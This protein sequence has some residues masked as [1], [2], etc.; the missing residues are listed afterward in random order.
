MEAPEILL[1]DRLNEKGV[2]IDAVIAHHPEAN[3]YTNF[4]EVM[5]MQADIFN[6]LGVSIS[7]AQ[8]MLSKRKREVAEKLMPANHYR[9]YDAARLLNISMLNFHTP[10]DNCV[11]TY[12]Q[13][14]FDKEK[15]TVIEGLMDLLMEIPEYIQSSKRGVPPMILVGDKKKKVQKVFVDMT[16][17]TSGPKE[18]YKRLSLA[19]IDTLVGMHFSDDHKKA[20]EEAGMHAVIAGHI[21]SDN[22]GMNL[23]LDEIEKKCGTLKIHEASGFTRIKRK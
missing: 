17:G 19:G 2:K 10:A 6:R 7:T 14:I 22:L 9:V 8:D 3:A 12:L 20:I 23:V 13:K 21:S 16:G 4:Y 15:P 1:A 18:I 5:D 11:A